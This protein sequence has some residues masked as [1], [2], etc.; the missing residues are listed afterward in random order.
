MMLNDPCAQTDGVIQSDALHCERD[1]S[2]L[3]I[4][5]FGRFWCCL[6]YEFIFSGMHVYALV[7][8]ISCLTESIQHHRPYR[9]K[10]GVRRRREVERC[11]GVED[12]QAERTG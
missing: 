2:Y 9:V 4:F 6:I 8:V 11:E 5:S 12:K 10:G 1:V 7:T 3:N